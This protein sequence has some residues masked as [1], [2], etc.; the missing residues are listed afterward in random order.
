MHEILAII[1]WITDLDT[2]PADPSLAF[3]DN[4]ISAFS[5]FVLCRSFLDHDAYAIYNTLM[6]CMLSW[7]DPSANVPSYA[8]PSALDT[9]SHIAQAAYV[10]P[11]VAKCSRIHDLLRRVDHDLW[12]RM[13]ELRIE[14]QIYGLKWLR[15]LFSR[16]FVIKD[17]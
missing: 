9:T 1:Y 11:I 17:T 2:I 15:L 7:Y 14:P 16:E 13:E 5:G 4:D 10:Q 3:D 8:Q 12:R 6:T